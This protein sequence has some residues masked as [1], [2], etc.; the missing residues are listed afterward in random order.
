VDRDTTGNPVNKE[1]EYFLIIFKFTWGEG[2]RA[3]FTFKSSRSG[4]VFSPNY[5]AI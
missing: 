3:A 4:G 5:C 1:I 2:F